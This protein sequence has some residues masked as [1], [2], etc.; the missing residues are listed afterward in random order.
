MLPPS[1]RAQR[2]LLLVSLIAPGAY[3]TTA[4][5]A[6][7]AEAPAPSATTQ[8]AAEAV[9]P[10]T[11]P[12]VVA[13][14]GAAEVSR[15]EL[16]RSAYL[17]QGRQRTGQARPALPK[18]AYQRLLDQI[19][20][21]KLLY[22]KA[23]EQGLVAS[24]A[25]IDA[26]VAAAEKRFQNPE[27]FAQALAADGMTREVLR[28]EIRETISIRKLVERDVVP[29]V[30][31]DEAAAKQFYDANPKPF[32]HP[33]QYRVAHLL[34]RVPRDAKPEEKEA[35]RKKAAELLAEAK[36]GADF[37]ELA[38]THS[39]DASK[40]AGGLLPWLAA[41][42]T[43]GPFEQAAMALAPGQLSEV[44]ETD[45]GFHLIKGVEKRAAGVLPFA[46]VKDRVIQGLR[47]QQ[48]ADSVVRYADELRKSAKIEVKL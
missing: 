37:A 44:V 20:G 27:A 31:V 41:G 6:A 10:T 9:D 43:V 36:A 16:V 21:A 35:A 38:K 8:A 13:V 23:I 3:V 4:S 39:D 22:Q 19:I 25:E 17:L 18:A 45:F 29:T 26:Q 24:E 42:D 34:L 7:A 1:L 32:E 40:A 48:L 30:Q 46:D 33:A 11:F 15:D 28:A 14:V 12:A 2:A 5:R 47:S